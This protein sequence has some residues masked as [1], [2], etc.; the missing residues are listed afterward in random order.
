FRLPAGANSPYAI[1]TGSDGNLWFVDQDAT[2]TVGKIDPNTGNITMYPGNTFGCGQDIISADGNLWVN[3]SFCYSKNQDLVS[4]DPN[5][6]A[7]T[8]ITGTTYPF[9][10]VVGITQGPDGNLWTAD[11]NGGRISTTRAISFDTLKP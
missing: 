6:G 7:I 11:F 3:V 1:T 10:G 4:I 9:S 8:T 5:A 2:G